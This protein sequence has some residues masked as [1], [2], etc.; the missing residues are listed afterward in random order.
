LHKKVIAAPAQQLAYVI[1]NFVVMAPLYRN[2]AKVAAVAIPVLGC[3]SF[4]LLLAGGL[5]FAESASVMPVIMYETMWAYVTEDLQ[6]GII[7]HSLL[8]GDHLYRSAQSMVGK[9]PKFFVPDG[10]NIFIENGALDSFGNNAFDPEGKYAEFKEASRSSG[11]NQRPY[12]PDFR[13]SIISDLSKIVSSDPNFNQIREWANKGLEPYTLFG[14]T[15]EDKVNESDLKKAYR[16]LALQYHPDKI[17]ESSKPEAD[18]YIKMI[19][20]A[21]KDVERNILKI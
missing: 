2:V 1:N 14:F 16:K 11:N 21:R 4:G 7:C 3:L 8:V 9:L 5:T 19:N 15:S 10:Y 12:S 6:R 17:T 20:T 13:R 18:I